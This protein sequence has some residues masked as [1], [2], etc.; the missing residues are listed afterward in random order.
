MK[1]CSEKGSNCQ[2]MQEVAIFVLEGW[3]DCCLK[4]QFH[5]YFLRKNV[6]EFL[7]WNWDIIAE[8]EKH[9]SKKES[10]PIKR[11]TKYIIEQ[12]ITTAEV[13]KGI[14]SHHCPNLVCNP[15]C[16]TGTSN[17]QYLQVQDLIN[18]GNF[19][20]GEKGRFRQLNCTC[21]NSIFGWIY[22]K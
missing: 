9:I 13:R 22:M 4:Q 11:Q 5:Q 20:Y 19:K 3:W 14:L 18:K 6:L 10:Y 7:P 15:A 12:T 2:T 17:Y 8:G 1:E 16:T 21:T